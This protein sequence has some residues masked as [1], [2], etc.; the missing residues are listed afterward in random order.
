MLQQTFLGASIIQFNG[1]VGW[2]NQIST[3]SVDL[4]ED[5]EN[6]DLFTPG[7]NGDPVIFTLG[8]F[9]FG[10]I[11]SNIDQQNNNAGNPTYSV[12]L[13]DPRDLF[14]GIQL[15]LNG[16]Y[17][18]IYNVPNVYNVYG[19]L[20]SQGGFGASQVNS[21]GMPWRLI[22]DTLISLVQ[23]TP[24]KHKLNQYYLDLSELPNLSGDF[25]VGGDNITLMD[26]INEVCTASAHDFFVYL[27]P[28]NIIKVYTI[29][30]SQAS[31][32]GAITN[33]I[34]S[35]EGAV[36]KNVGTELRN[37]TTSKFLVGGNIQKLYY[38]QMTYD[39][40]SVDRSIALLEDGYS[41]YSNE[42][43][44]EVNKYKSSKDNILPFWE[45][46]PSSNDLIIG[47]GFFESDHYTMRLNTTGILLETI[48][49]EDYYP[50]D[51]LELRAA[52][53]GIDSWMNFI[54]WAGNIPTS[55][56]K[57]KHKV[58]RLYQNN[59]PN[60][61]SL[62]NNKSVNDIAQMKPAEFAGFTRSLL[63]RL[64][65]DADNPEVKDIQRIFAFVNKVATEYYGKRFAVRIPQIGR[66]IDTDTGIVTTSI[67]PA[68]GGYLDENE[69]VDAVNNNRMPI[70]FNRLMTQD[71]KIQAYAKFTGISDGK[72]D[73]SSLSE[74]DYIVNSYPGRRDQSQL[75]VGYGDTLFVKCTLSPNIAFEKYYSGLGPVVLV[76]LPSP[77]YKYTDDNDSS[78]FR[79]G[80][81]LKMM[82][83]Y[84]LNKKGVNQQNKTKI[85]K[86]IYDR[87]GKDF[88]FDEFGGRAKRPDAIVLP[89]KDNTLSYGPWYAVGGNGKTEY[90]R[91][92]SLVPWN[93]GNYTLLNLAGNAKVNSAIS[94]QLDAEA[95]VITVPGF[96]TLGIGSQLIANGPYVSDIQVSAGQ[97]GVTTQYTMK[98]WFARPMSL[99]VQQVERLRKIE[100]K[101]QSAKRAYRDIYTQKSRVYDKS[102]LQ[103]VIKE[104]HISN[105][106]KNKSTQQLIMGEVYPSSSYVAGSTLYNALNQVGSNYNKKAF[107]TW[108]AIFR[109]FSTDP[110]ASGIAKFERPSNS[111]LI[112]TTYMDILKESD[113]TILSYGEEQLDASGVPVG[114]G[115]P[116]DFINR[117]AES[118]IRGIALKGPLIISGP[119]F[120]TEGNPVPG[121]GGQ[122][123][124]DY[125]KRPDQWKT[126]VL[127]TRWDDERKVW[128]AGGSSNN[129]FGILRDTISVDGSGRINE[130]II[131]SGDVKDNQTE[132]YG[133]AFLLPS[134][135]SLPAG[136][137][138]T[139]QDCNGI[140][141]INGAGC[142][143]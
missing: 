59:N 118:G 48:E 136:T 90:E 9:S 65:N 86:D 106:H 14:N 127:D 17:G 112:E 2:N 111:S 107:T 61:F 97:N 89:L 49:L 66:K 133:F 108:D 140:Q 124:D 1:S 13:V 47:K 102:T 15:I 55:P 83:S 138:V 121:S 44:N 42:I 45:F 104:N 62:L 84:H 76:E 73:I 21:T 109:P 19:Y 87:I 24:I 77:V 74:N 79:V 27:L 25:R 18:G 35:I 123:I 37:E 34:N 128:V 60:L 101:N 120:D 57:D 105:K 70:D 41:T 113:I 116:N 98:S 32:P 114:S 50:T 51:T 28:G 8:G 58:F 22:R 139:T 46:D 56:H 53:G 110:E 26:F 132:Y 93:Y 71:G 85:I 137:K 75:L 81:V 5:P 40:D 125:K 7:S 63:S 95:G 119:G 38:E 88:L 11:I 94:N 68:D 3:L 96:P 103:S 78:K 69:I 142:W 80:G 6:G 100:L 43:N 91:D 31:I 30:R 126:G 122:F 99:G 134:G 64:T 29:D 141:I 52:Y 39:Q 67:E 129:R 54:S 143:V 36:A 115:I 12:N 20:E 82:L 10:G 135:A 23:T 131:A 92:E 33:F 16:Y 72:L 4:A 130:R 117:T